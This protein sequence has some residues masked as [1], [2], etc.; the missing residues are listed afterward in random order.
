MTKQEMKEAVS[1]FR[2]IELKKYG[3]A[4]IWLL[5]TG[6]G[7][8]KAWDNWGEGNRAEGIADILQGVLDSDPD[9]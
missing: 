3:K 8:R 7:L 6:V 5:V 9:K 2:S 1:E 4:I